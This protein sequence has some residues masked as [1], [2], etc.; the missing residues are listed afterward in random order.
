MGFLRFFP[1]LL[2]LQNFCEVSGNLAA[3]DSYADICSAANSTPL[4]EN[5][6]R[7][8]N[9]IY[10]S[11]TNLCDRHLDQKWY[12]SNVDI[13]T[14]CPESLECGTPF[15]LWLNGSLPTESEGSVT[16]SVCKRGVGPQGCCVKTYDIKMKNC[17]TFLA[18]CL[19]PPAECSERYCFG[20][21]ETCEVPAPTMETTA[22][23]TGEDDEGTIVF[24]AIS[25][26]LIGVI[27]IIAFGLKYFT[28]KKLPFSISKGPNEQNKPQ[29]T[30]R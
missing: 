27:L 20:S 23:S 15:P 11:T 1:I 19:T 8:K 18:Y 5:Y 30:P 9:C 16:R 6:Y 3:C 26:T 2:I 17:S 14:S 10:N 24:V 4:H 25:F 13:L 22:E 21:N 28:L 29:T 7:S 12:R